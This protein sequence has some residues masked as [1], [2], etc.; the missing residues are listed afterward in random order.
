MSTTETAIIPT[1]PVRR[2]ILPPERDARGAAQLSA[3]A[4]AGRR[5]L[6]PTEGLPARRSGPARG[7]TVRRHLRCAL[8][9]TLLAI[10]AI[11][12]LS[13]YAAAGITDARSTALCQAHISCK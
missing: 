5:Y 1:V 13:S 10:V 7:A 9:G 8:T 3:T 12:G 11:T 6:T 4:L 2:P